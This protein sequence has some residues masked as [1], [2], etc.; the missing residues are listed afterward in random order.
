MKTIKDFEII[1]HGIENEQ[2]FQGCG[3]AFTK[4]KNVVTGIGGSEYE[5]YCDATDQMAVGSDDDLDFTELDKEGDKAS[6]KSDIPEDFNGM[7][8]YVSIRWN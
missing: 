5:A 3:V 2:Y 1:N 4:F 7:Y 8:H 6:K